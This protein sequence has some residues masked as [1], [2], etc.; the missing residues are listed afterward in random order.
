M[1]AFTSKPSQGRQL[2]PPGWREGKEKSGELLNVSCLLQLSPLPALEVGGKFT[3]LEVRIFSIASSF[4]FWRC[5]PFLMKSRALAYESKSI[6]NNC[7]ICDVLPMVR[8]DNRSTTRLPPIRIKIP[9]TFLGK[10]RLSG[11]WLN[12]MHLTI[13]EN[14]G[15]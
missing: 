2:H 5:S 8:C 6:C 9:H 15:V 12:T 10:L 1:L 3:P 7:S 13:A 14:R 11:R 4:R